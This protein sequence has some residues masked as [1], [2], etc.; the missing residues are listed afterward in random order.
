MKALKR[1]SIIATALAVALLLGGIVM[2]SQQTAARFPGTLSVSGVGIPE[3]AIRL[4]EDQG[5]TIPVKGFHVD[6]KRS[7]GKPYQSADRQAFLTQSTIVPSEFSIRNEGKQTITLPNICGSAS[8]FPAS[9]VS[10]RIGY[11]GLSPLIGEQ[12]LSY[13]SCPDGFTLAPGKGL[14]VRA[15]VYVHPETQLGDH[16]IELNLDGFLVEGF[17]PPPAASIAL[18]VNGSEQPGPVAYNSLL[19]V[20]WSA[21]TPYC[22]HAGDRISGRS[23]Q[24][25][26]G[27]SEFHGG[28]GPESLRPTPGNAKLSASTGDSWDPTYQKVLN[29]SLFCFGPTPDNVATRMIPISVLPPPVTPGS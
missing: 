27:F 3:G 21:N 26:P 22:I 14:R 10:T 1:P 17:Q 18:T 19:D 2:A 23:I 16:T 25:S 11:V 4:Y 8:I 6:T 5:M 29:L 15:S 13:W 24:T 9:Q 12:W 28:W 7:Y 20:S